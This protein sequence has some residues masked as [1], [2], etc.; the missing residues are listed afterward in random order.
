[1]AQFL[2]TVT[3]CLTTLVK[4]SRHAGKLLVVNLP[5][6]QTQFRPLEAARMCVS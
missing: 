2:G 5:K 3:L 6:T 1:M 4:D